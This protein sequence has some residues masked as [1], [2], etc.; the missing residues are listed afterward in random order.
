M[1]LSGN[2]PIDRVS[3]AEST[4]P[5]E[6]VPV[7]HPAAVQPPSR[8]P[9]YRKPI[10]L[11]DT[12]HVDA[13]ERHLSLWDLIAIGV[14]GTIGSGLFV[15]AGL[16]A[17]KYAGPAAVLSWILSGVAA[18]LSGSC[19]A[20]LATH[21]HT[22]GGAYAYAYAGLG[23]FP[24]V[25]TA[26][27]LSVDYI[28]ASAAVAR[29]WGDKCVAWIGLE[30]GEDHFLHG[31]VQ[32]RGSFSP[33]AFLIST[34]VVVLL[35]NGVKESKA[36]TNIFTSLKV[37]VSVFMVL[38]GFYLTNSS[39]WEPFVPPEY[40]AAGVVRGATATFFGYLGYDA[41]C[42]LGGEAI[43][44]KRNLPIAIL[45]TLAG[46]TLLYVTATLALT[47]ML[48]YDQISPVS[49][50]PDAFYALEANFAGQIAA[51]GEL[52]TLPIVVLISVMAQP[53]LMLAMGQDGLLPPYFCN[54]DDS[55][56]LWNGTFFSGIVMVFVATFIPFE[57]LNDMISFAVLS[58]LNFVDSSLVLLW[59]EPREATPNLAASLLFAFHVAALLTSV[60]VTDYTE[61]WFGFTAATVCALA[62]VLITLLLYLFCPKPASF[63]GQESADS[64]YFRTPF[65][66]FWPC[67]GIA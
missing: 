48:P 30:L 59:H 4:V 10:F 44:P 63:G 37:A 15:L 53:R 45:C 38:V 43:E 6:E 41:V 23:E 22:P 47:G 27:C 5:M 25:L 11:A 20:E 3:I 46:V 21:I 33:L 40:G 57:R 1:H 58:I 29:S 18:C 7:P 56:N 26:V 66:P 13:M 61:S 36:V 49:G 51:L 35:L 64:G 67:I 55:G 39:N 8:S 24:A 60:F 62:M 42:C 12:D 19:Y 65:V 17:H 16:V 34:L 54:V 50:F 14:G 2:N 32:S 52:A 31:L 9:F 28:S